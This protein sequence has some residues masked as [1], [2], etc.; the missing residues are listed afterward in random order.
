MSVRK[1]YQLL[2][3]GQVIATGSY[4]TVVSCYNSTYEALQLLGSDAA[5]VIAFKPV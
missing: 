5:L 2:L 3:N 4:A 1:V